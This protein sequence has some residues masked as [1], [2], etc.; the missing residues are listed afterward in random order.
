VRA[1]S[2]VASDLLAVSLAI[3]STGE[4]LRIDLHN[5]TLTPVAETTIITARPALRPSGRLATK[6]YP[7]GL[8]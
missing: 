4:I 2:S 3:G 7:A 8:Q 5:F 6:M 1:F